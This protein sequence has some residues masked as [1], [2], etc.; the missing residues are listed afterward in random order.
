MY[1]Y[2]ARGPTEAACYFYT[3]RITIT[4]SVRRKKGKEKKVD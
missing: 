3:E 4:K 1:V 2:Y